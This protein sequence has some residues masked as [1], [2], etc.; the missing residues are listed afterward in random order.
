MS[1]PNRK[2]HAVTR[3]RYALTAALALACVNFRP[4]AAQTAQEP[5]VT[6]SAEAAPPMTKG[7]QRLAKLLEGRVAG[8][9]V[10][11]IQTARNQRMQ[12]IDGTAYVYGSGKTIY[13]QRTRNPASINNNDALV[14]LRYSG[15][16][17]CRQE[18]ITTIDRFLGF[19]TGA[20]FFEDF[21]PYT[22][23]KAEA[24]EG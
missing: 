2:D 3:F 8:T 9:P 5:D 24:A 22:R 17:L 18:F 14:M 23:E 19:P 7:E 4:L 10:D 6:A 20:V 1:I 16:Q 12:T 13:V 15:T 11:C 21:I